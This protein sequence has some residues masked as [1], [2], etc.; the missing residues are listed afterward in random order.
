MQYGLI[1]MASYSNRPRKRI[2]IF[3]KPWPL[4]NHGIWHFLRLDLFYINMQMNSEQSIPFIWRDRASF[5]ILQ[6]W[7]RICVKPMKHSIWQSMPKEDLKYQQSLEL[8]HFLWLG[9]VNVNVFV[10]FW[11]KIWSI[12]PERQGHFHFFTILTS[13]NVYH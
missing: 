4:K 1:I 12:Q 10:P 8:W 2:W 13:A 9:S 3:G 6:L 7:P 5:T 11:S